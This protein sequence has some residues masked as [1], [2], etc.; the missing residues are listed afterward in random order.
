MCPPD[1]VLG[2]DP[3]RVSVG[4]KAWAAKYAADATDDNG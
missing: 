2:I 3:V 4:L 1:G